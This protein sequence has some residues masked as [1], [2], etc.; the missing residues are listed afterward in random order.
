MSL[1]E[2]F[3]AFDPS[4]EILLPEP[5][6]LRWR[7]APWDDV[8]TDEGVSDVEASDDE[9]SVSSIDTLQDYKGSPQF[10]ILA[11]KQPPLLTVTP[12]CY[13]TYHI[14]QH[15]LTGLITGLLALSL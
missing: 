5:C 6:I 9:Q 2:Y 3:S 12:Q 14:H 10:N 8:M 7:S 11:K 1:A 13:P 15:S 4:S